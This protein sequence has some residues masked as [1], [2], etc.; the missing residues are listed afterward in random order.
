MKNISLDDKYTT[1]TGRIYLSGI[2]ALVRLPIIQRMRDVSD[3]LNTAGFISGYRGSP[4]G[5][6]D[7]AYWHAEK[8]LAANHI[9]FQ[10]GINEDLALTSVW[11]TQQVKL[12]GGS[13][14]DGVFGLW[15]A[16]GPGVDRSIDVM[17]H[18][19]HAGTSRHGGVIM[20]AGDDHGAYSSTLPHQ[21]DHV[22]GAAMVPILYP[23][24]VQEYI[25]LG[26][27][28]WAMSRFS[29]CAVGFKALA[30]T[31]ESSA[32]IEADPFHIETRIP[33]DF[34]MPEGGLNCR[35]LSDAIGMQARKQEA[36]MQDYKIYAALAYAR[37][38]KLNHT[39]INS[40]NA[41]L[42]IIASGKSYLD[43]IEALSE[44][45][46]DEA[47]AGELGI[48]L[49]K[50]AMPWP[51]EP[52]SV[53]EFATGLDEILVVEEKRQIVEYQLKEQLYNWR[54][55][56]RP[57]VIGKFDEK[58]EWV[59]PR[60][61][62]LL[63]SKVDFS[64]A[65]IARVIASRI[66]RFHT[67]EPI[68]ER[69]KF[70]DEKEAVLRLA[71]NTPPRP[72]YYCSGCPHNTSTK[73]PQGSL[74]LAGIGCHAMATSIYPEFNK[75]LTHMGGEGAP[76]I[77]QAHF[78]DRKHIF[79]NLGDGTYF[80]SGS[81]AI[82]AAIAA[83]VNI[84]YKIL[85]NSAVAMTGG[86]PVDGHISVETIANQ[87]VSEGVQRLA[88]VTEDLSRYEDR[89]GLPSIA[90]IHDRKDMEAVQLELREVPGTSILIYDQVCAAEKRRKRKKKE[91]VEPDERVFINPLV[92]EGCGD[93]GVQSNCVSILPLETEFG[94]KRVISQSTCNKDYSCVNGFCPSFVTV[95]GGH[96]RKLGTTV[97]LIPSD[98]IPQPNVVKHDGT[99]NILIT[100]I[101]G[102]GVITI[103]ALLGM[104]AHL[105]GKG[106]SVLDMTGM[107]QKNGA[108]MSHVRLASNPHNIKA[109]RIATG[110]ADLILGCDLL[111]AGSP[112]VIAKSRPDKTYAIIN[113][114]EQPPGQ[115]ARNP[116]WTF[117]TDSV[118]Q[119]LTNAVGGQIEYINATKIATGLLG[120]AIGANLFMLGLAYQ[121]GMIPL[122]FEAI[123]RA[124]ELNGVA[125]NMNLAAFSWGR[126]AA[127]NLQEVERKASPMQPVLM[128]RP[129][130]LEHILQLRT[131]FLT[132]Y[133]NAAYAE[134]YL[135]FVKRV[136]N[137]ENA[138]G[139]GEKFTREVATY[140]FKLMSYKDEYEVARL[141]T[142]P[143]FQQA[144]NE[145]FEGD[146]VIEFN[147]APPLLAKRDAEGK[148]LKRRFPGITMHAF[149]ILAKL[150]F[151]RGSFFDVFGRTEERRTERQLIEEYEDTIETLLNDL[152]AETHSTIVSIAKLPEHI[153][154]YG[155]V[156]EASIAIARAR[157]KELLSQ[158]DNLIKTPA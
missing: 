11:G 22:F 55:D 61:E 138:A 101:G 121:R 91:M 58:G 45:G 85:Y 36:L 6:L 18:M 69:L 2:Q 24:N 141:F 150:R 78:S 131:E 34:V 17:K 98:S 153:R 111:T 122:S 9:L 119:L 155:H 115:F 82:R 104:A 77:G 37:A 43:V 8:H 154:G 40:P 3:G 142:M 31:V 124:I 88:I 94:R 134:R 52:D 114:H 63:S 60:G 64:I 7:E 48:R 67:S 35:L 123:V 140:L 21:S 90:T 146:F 130:S 59:H 105:E 56:V 117:P 108:V 49:F 38:N 109:Q 139:L 15:Y 149:K 157:Q 54:D 57:R 102:T 23:C 156:K 50:V 143:E 83:R 39:T 97:A 95:K 128:Q 87:M 106:A 125:V 132:Q 100:G 158:I 44:L 47:C 112:D 80:H 25:E 147:L 70:L 133:Q 103:G 30:D 107:S 137:A 113:T 62:W 53:R 118:E 81:L 152:N 65:Q 127:L 76:W 1:T 89:V 79:A 110:E 28:A 46:I 99:Y 93:C 96:L 68:K 144:L 73:V 20:V 116:D 4:L 14:Y 5:G 33:T 27:H 92:C 151:L 126:Q 74:A 72:A 120:D 29:G 12:I 136:R 71:V 148:L 86:Q 13:P 16:K 145:T 84:T 75:T 41:R 66:A 42:G 135:A 32:S 51:L 129:G 19:N 26:L 10:P